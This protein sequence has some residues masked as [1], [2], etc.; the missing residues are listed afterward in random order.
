[1]MFKKLYFTIII[2]LSLSSCL[3]NRGSSFVTGGDA[4]T[5]HNCVIS[6]SIEE[7]PYNVCLG[8]I[9][10]IPNMD[11]VLQQ[12]L[13]IPSTYNKAIICG[14][15]ASYLA[16]ESLI[17]NINP[18][19]EDNSWLDKYNQI[20][21]SNDPTGASTSQTTGKKAKKI[22][23][24]AKEETGKNWESSLQ[25]TEFSDG[26]SATSELNPFFTSLTYQITST[27]SSYK[28]GDLPYALNSTINK[29]NFIEGGGAI[30]NNLIWNY[31]FLY[32]RYEKEIIS[33]SS[34]NGKPMEIIGFKSHN[35]GHFITLNGYNAS[36]SDINFKF[37][38]SV[39][40]EKWYKIRNVK[41]NE[42]FCVIKSKTEC[43]RYAKVAQMPPLFTGNE[44]SYLIESA[45]E[46]TSTNNY[47]FKV[48]AHVSGINAK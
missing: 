14:P 35:S 4:G 24:I 12:S 37:H 33:E 25:N 17:K 38:C 23:S 27:S 26:I 16:L 7:G 8:S 28:T 48:I 34:Y 15:V 1:M 21:N 43:L 32:L 18:Y 42:P 39:Y 30:N 36:S 22:I 11:I 31:I 19:V 45:G 47:R 44:F 29:C 46:E 2:S 6:S 13:N 41:L 9:C 3:N 10:S 40:G 5:S 20:T